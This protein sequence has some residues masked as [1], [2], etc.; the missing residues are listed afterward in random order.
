MCKSQIR[1]DF[2]RLPRAHMLMSGELN[3]WLLFMALKME[4]VC[5]RNR[6]IGLSSE[7]IPR[8]VSIPQ[9]FPQAE[10]DFSGV[11]QT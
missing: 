4:N 5:S 9:P 6:P 11:P 8:G 1:K 10:C 3:N 2:N 7:E